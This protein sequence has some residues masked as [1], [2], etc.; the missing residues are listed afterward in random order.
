MSFNQFRTNPG[1][2]VSKFKGRTETPRAWPGTAVSTW[3]NSA[4][5]SGGSRQGH[6]VP[7]FRTD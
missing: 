7:N 4:L 1:E 5:F 2:S 6:N 3:M